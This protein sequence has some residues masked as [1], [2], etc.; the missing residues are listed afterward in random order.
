[1]RYECARELLDNLELDEKC[2][3]RIDHMLSVLPSETTLGMALLLPHKEITVSSNLDVKVD[4]IECGN[5][6][7]ARQKIL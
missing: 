1:M 7:A 6:M 3:A 4:D 5:E 2:D